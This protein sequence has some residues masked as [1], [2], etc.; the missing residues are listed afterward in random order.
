MDV[1]KPHRQLRIDM[2]ARVSIVLAEAKN[3]L[4]IPS[5]A[6]GERQP[7][8]D[9]TVRVLNADGQAETRTVRVG[10]NNNVRAEVKSGLKEGERVIVGEQDAGAPPSQSGGRRRSPMGF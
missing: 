5:T 4:T 6:L 10:L 7:S 1:D 3:V 9:Y 2:T 8:G